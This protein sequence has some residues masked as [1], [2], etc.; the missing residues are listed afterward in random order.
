MTLT[1]VD[2]RVC[3]ESESGGMYWITYAGGGDC[4]G[5]STWECSCPAGRRGHDC[6][7]MAAFLGS[8]LPNQIGDPDPALPTEIVI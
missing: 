8:C 7:H 2:E 6:K 4:D 1:I 3:V 5:V